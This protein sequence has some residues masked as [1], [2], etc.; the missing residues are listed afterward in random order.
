[1]QALSPGYRTVLVGDR[2]M[3]RKIPDFRHVILN[4]IQNLSEFGDAV[5]GKITDS[6]RCA[7]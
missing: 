4:L 5:V 6:R 1:M 3:S 2:A 7:G